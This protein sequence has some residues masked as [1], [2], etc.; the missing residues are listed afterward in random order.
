MSDRYASRSGLLLW[1]TCL[2]SAVLASLLL[3]SWSGRAVRDLPAETS[4]PRAQD[5][6]VTQLESQIQQL[7]ERVR[8]LETTQSLA[9]RREAA[10]RRP[11]EPTVDPLRAGALAEVSRRVARL[12]ALE[13]ARQQRAAQTA[14]RQAGSHHQRQIGQLVRRDAAHNVIL[15]MDATDSEKAQAWLS[16]AGLEEYPW[17]DEIIAAVTHIGATSESDRAR[18]V[19]WIGADSHHRSDVLVRPLIAAL[20]DSVANVREEAADALGHYLDV[21]G[22]REALL[23]T[24]NNDTSAKVRDEALRVLREQ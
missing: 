20:S 24:S 15:D 12:E 6:Q 14:E 19:V 17:T 16:L 2:A 7:E 9:S 23:W 3:N 18:E 8:T 21:S 11:V 22:V 10:S 4:G 5:P 13:E 1:V